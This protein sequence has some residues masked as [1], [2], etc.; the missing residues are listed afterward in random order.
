[1]KI[2]SS[3]RLRHRNKKNAWDGENDEKISFRSKHLR[4][5]AG[6]RHENT[7]LHTCA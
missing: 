3:N 7:T 2:Y 4:I 6:D 5:S 1:M